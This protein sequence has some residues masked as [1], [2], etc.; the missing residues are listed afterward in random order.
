M[1]KIFKV[2]SFGLLFLICFN[3]SQV[4]YIKAFAEENNSNP[5]L[6][7]ICDKIR[8]LKITEGELQ[9]LLDF[10][11]SMEEAEYYYKLNEIVKQLEK[12]N[13]KVDLRD[14]IKEISD[15]DFANNISYY[16]EQILLGNEAALK[17][18]LRTLNSLFEGK[19]Y[20][21]K[22][23]R[24]FSNIESYEVIFPDGGKVIYSVKTNNQDE[25]NRVR[26]VMN[27]EN[28][29]EGFNKPD[30]G[31]E[32]VLMN[33]GITYAYKNLASREGQW[34]FQSGLSYSKVYLYT[35]F[36]LM[37]D[38]KS[39]IT[40]GRGG[41]SSYGIV[42]VANSTGAF[43]SREKNE[44]VKKP[45]EARNEVIFTVTAAFGAA[46]LILSMSINSGLSWTQYII[47]RLYGAEDLGKDAYGAKYTWYAAA[48]K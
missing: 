6:K 45:A 21:Y 37:E 38:K 47:F 9:E 3:L 34:A 23:L 2:I 42:N 25:K 18:A 22:L 1:K 24:T 46:F 20:T 44:G 30:K 41:Q 28:D 33:E 40:Y 11:L 48:Y 29:I 26:E 36:I 12:H 35:E 17:K 4:T 14:N 32:E 27:G 8:N 15:D 39:Y 43:I 31:Y 16:R 19:N 13:I 5:K 10:G 7:D